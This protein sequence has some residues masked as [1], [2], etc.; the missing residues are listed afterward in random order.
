MTA[1]LF[2][3]LAVSLIAAG[4]QSPAQ[5]PGEGSPA[6]K[7]AH[8]IALPDDLKWGD[9]PPALPAGTKMA[10]LSG[11]PSKEGSVFTIR[12][13]FVDGAKIPPHWHSTDELVTVIE[14]SFGLGIGEKFDKDK[15][16]FLP[17]GTFARLD[18]GE[19]HYALC[20]GTTI[21]Q[22]TGVGPFDLNFVNPEDAP[23]K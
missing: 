17:P 13:K 23:K 6:K 10:V 21:V 4:T 1:R 7:L 2:A 12:A 9:A 18:K 8:M 16:R 11:D 15:V 19:R 20:K 22:V 3:V 14:G 5:A